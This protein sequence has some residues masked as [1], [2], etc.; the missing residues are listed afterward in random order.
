MITLSILLVALCTGVGFLWLARRAALAIGLVDRPDTRK[1]HLG[2]VP[3]AGGAG[4]YA[5]LVA[6]ALIAWPL[7]PY[8]ASGVAAIVLG[9]LAL[10]I[11]MIDDARGLTPKLR[12]VL[13]IGLAL[14]LTA[15][16]HI[17]VDGLGDV[18]GTGAIAFGVVG[19]TVFTAFCIVGALNATNMS[20][21][22][23][24]LLA[25][26]VGLS[27][28]ALATLMID[29]GNPPEP[30]AIATIGAL[31]AFLLFNLGAFGPARRLFLGDSG[32]TL[33][34]LVL[35]VLVIGAAQGP[36][37]SIEPVTA[38][39]LLGLPLLDTVVVVVRRLLQGRSPLV[40]GRDHL[41][42]LLQ[43]L[44]LSPRRTLCAMVAL[45]SLLLA[46]GFVA[47]FS[48]LPA[49]VFLYAFVAITLA[50]LAASTAMARRIDSRE[51]VPP[52]E[53]EPV[54]PLPSA[55]APEGLAGTR[56]P[57]LV[58]AEPSAPAPRPA[59]TAAPANARSAARRR[60][61]RGPREKAF[62]D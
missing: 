25:S 5:A 57:A 50:H 9:L 11:G 45:H 21:G 41:H 24:G 12:L 59:R 58:G 62:A 47:E 26:L 16:F 32:S 15:G 38:G 8:G 22:L 2:E 33:L 46:G 48:A 42:H 56:E 20:D 14:L 30:L 36:V 43:D 10:V 61:A 31:G 19:S 51:V 55:A 23:D 52:T 44:G 35:G 54:V 4:V 17:Q 13:Q 34:G 3:L 6:T 49:W 53:I 60:T 39:W 37:P 28:A 27:L 40:A 29:A 1:R 7:A 18:F